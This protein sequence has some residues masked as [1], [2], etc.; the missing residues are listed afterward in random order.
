M[1]SF[2]SVLKSI[3]V[4]RPCLYVTLSVVLLIGVVLEDTGDGVEVLV[5]VLPVDEVL[6][7][8]LQET[9]KPAIPTIE[10]VKSILFF[11]TKTFL[12]YLNAH[13]L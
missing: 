7:F 13:K 3:D 6:P 1:T 11:I 9:N 8:V 5:L 12:L 4:P 10:S 2:L